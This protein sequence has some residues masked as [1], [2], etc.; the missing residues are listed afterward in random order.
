M[1]NDIAPGKSYYL[2]FVTLH[3]TDATSPNI[4]DYD[5]FVQAEANLNPKNAV[6]WF[7]VGSTQTKA[8][9]D[10]LNFLR[11][12][13][14]YLVDGKLRVS[15][16]GAGLWNAGA[17]N[18]LSPINSDPFG[19]PTMFFEAW[20]GTTSTGAI[21]APDF[22]G[23]GADVTVGS[24]NAVN[25]D[26]IRCRQVGSIGPDGLTTECMYGVSELLTAVKAGRK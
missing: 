8:A 9:K 26:W 16:T 22:L 6:K 5:T 15:N 17:V 18:L 2:A 4:Q 20:T 14:V 1:P 3:E 12:P 23:S 13:P 25:A 10:H 7:A 11:E 21:D 19:Q 24:L